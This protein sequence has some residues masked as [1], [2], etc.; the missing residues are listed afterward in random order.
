MRLFWWFSNNVETLFFQLTKI[1]L[2]RRVVNARKRGWLLPNSP[3]APRILPVR[4]VAKLKEKLREDARDGIVSAFQTK[5][6]ENWVN[7]NKDSWSY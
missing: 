5:L 1:T 7:F 4:L 3:N 2:F 6:F